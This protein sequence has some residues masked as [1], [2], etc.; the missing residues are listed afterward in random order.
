M[1]QYTFEIWGIDG[2]FHDT[3]SAQNEDCAWEMINIKYPDA[4]YIDLY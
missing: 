4:A 1:E 3:V 2:R